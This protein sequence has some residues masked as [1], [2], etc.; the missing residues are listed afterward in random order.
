M[1]G[2]LAYRLDK[3]WF[4][5]AAGITI[6]LVGFSGIYLG[7]HF[8]LDVLFG[9]LLGLIVVVAFIKAE[10]FMP[11]TLITRLKSSQA[12]LAFGISILIILVGLGIHRLISTVDDPASWAAYA[13]A[14]RSMV[15]YFVYAGVL[16]G[17]ALGVIFMNAS[18]GF[19][20]SGSI[21]IKVA[22]GILGL[23]GVVL[24]FIC[25]NWVNQQFALADT[26]LSYA[27]RYLQVALMTFWVLIGAPWLFLKFKLAKPAPLERLSHSPT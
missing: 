23:A 25:G 11:R 27:L 15:G 26:A 2:Y 7:L 13:T 5:A 12:G 8:P 10:P 6:V 1:L 22:R 9:W 17:V 21:Y 19:R 14:G 24:I 4:W 3:A 20:N 16:L 18:V